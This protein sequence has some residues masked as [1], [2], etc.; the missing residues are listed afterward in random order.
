MVESGYE[1]L[2]LWL[3]FEIFSE[4]EYDY[5]NKPSMDIALGLRAPLCKEK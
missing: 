1:S 5:Q 2:L 3:I 4:C